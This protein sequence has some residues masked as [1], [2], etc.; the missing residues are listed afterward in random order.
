MREI[1]AYDGVKTLNQLSLWFEYPCRAFRQQK[2]SSP[3]VSCVCLPGL[4]LQ[5]YQCSALPSSD[6]ICGLLSFCRTLKTLSRVAPKATPNSE[7]F[8]SFEVVLL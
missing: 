2:Q 7:R 1:F 4:L 8:A 5:I 6:P 3:P